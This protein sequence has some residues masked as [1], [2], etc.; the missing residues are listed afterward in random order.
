LP[1]KDKPVRTASD[2]DD[3]DD[4]DDLFQQVGDL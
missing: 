2:D 4:D 3:D 1:L